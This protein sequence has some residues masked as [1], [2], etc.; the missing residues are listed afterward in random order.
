MNTYNNIRDFMRDINNRQQDTIIRGSILYDAKTDVVLAYYK[1]EL[2]SCY[3]CNCIFH[4]ID[5]MLYC[6]GF[7]GCTTIKDY[8]H[9]CKMWRARL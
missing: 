8:A 6:G 9:D 5:G 1:K 4:D 7:G 3:D 2:H